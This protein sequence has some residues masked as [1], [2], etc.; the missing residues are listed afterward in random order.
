MTMLELFA[1]V[2]FLL[3]AGY[4]CSLIKEKEEIED[5]KTRDTGK[6]HRKD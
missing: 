3:M 5:D 1:L 4:L 2:T 6:S